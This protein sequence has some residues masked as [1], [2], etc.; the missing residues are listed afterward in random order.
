[1]F[2][3]FVGALISIKQFP[4][5]VVEEA[6]SAIAGPVLGS[7][8]AL[9]CLAIYFGTGSQLFAWLAYIGVF[10]NLFNLL[11]MSPLDGGRVIGAV[12]RGFWVVGIVASVILATIW[13]S[14]LLFLI[15]VFGLS[16]INKRYLAV[17]WSVY[18]LLGAVGLIASALNG[19]VFLGVVIAYLCWSQG[20]N[21]PLARRLAQVPT[22]QPKSFKMS[23][24]KW[25]PLRSGYSNRIGIAAGRKL[26]KSLSKLENS[27]SP[28]FM[29][30]KK[31]RIIIGT[32][33]VGLACTLTG[34][35]I[36]MHSAGLFTRPHS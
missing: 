18:A 17:H 36:W 19:E 15:S 3:P 2:I 34:I 4:K 21:A 30:P 16:E 5:S 1:M 25:C 22:A 11:P 8:G 28:Y 13:G 33:Y 12:W 20:K 26:H 35:L 10:L 14:A 31:Q 27:S 24:A 29:V 9:V 23:G 7:V 32:M 6:Y